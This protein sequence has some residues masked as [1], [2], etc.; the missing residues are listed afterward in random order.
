[1]RP[2]GRHIITIGRDLIKDKYAAIVELVKNAYDADSPNCKISL[3]PF[4]KNEQKGVKVIVKDEGHGMTY[5]TVVDKWMVPSTNDKLERKTSP[6]GR[7]LQGKKGIGRYSASIIGD[8]LVLQTI[9]EAGELT[10]LY[11]IWKDF[12][13]AKYLEDVDVLIE[14][15][16]T[17]NSKS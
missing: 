13:K 6:R 12:E 14:N 2:A 7:I 16:Y 1:I 4:E 17:S 10:T 11:L 5:D 9:D 3:L 15:F 8:D